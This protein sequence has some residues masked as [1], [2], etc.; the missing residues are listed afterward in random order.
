MRLELE[1]IG[2]LKGKHSFEFKKGLNL[3]VA[4][5]GRGASSVVRGMRALIDPAPVSEVLFQDVVKG[6]VT[7]SLDGSEYR[8]SVRRTASGIV[9]SPSELANRFPSSLPSMVIV[10]ENHPLTFGRLSAESLASYLSMVSH[11]EELT[12][13]IEK[14][15][16]NI[17]AEESLLSRLVDEERNRTNQIVEYDKL[18]DDLHDARVKGRDLAESAKKYPNIKES[19]VLIK[20]M[21]EEIGV[22]R[23]EKDEFEKRIESCNRE[24]ASWE[25][26]LKSAK[27]TEG[28]QKALLEQL[29]VEGK[30][31]ERNLRES[32]S[33]LTIFERMSI[34]ELDKCP[35]C[36]FL[37]IPCEFEK[38]SSEELRRCI[39]VGVATARKNDIKC[40]REH[41]HKFKEI[42]AA[43]ADLKI[44][45]NNSAN[46]TDNI[47]RKQSERKE[48]RV[49]LE[50]RSLELQKLQSKYKES[51]KE[52]IEAAKLLAEFELVKKR[53]DDLIAMQKEK[54]ANGRP[55]RLNTAQK[56]RVEKEL[57]ENRKELSQSKAALDERLHAIRKIF[58][59][60]AAKIMETAGYFTF[61]KLFID[62][63]YRIV[64]ERD[65]QKT[66]QSLSALSTS[67]ITSIAVLIAAWG[68]KAYCPDFPF[69]AIDTVSTFYD[70]RTL[71][72]ISKV[73]LSSG[74]YVVITRPVPGVEN[75]EV[76]HDYDS[77][78]N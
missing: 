32:T 48:A 21:A 24:I 3:V 4:R 76:R 49:Q 66:S 67:E 30:T 41:D 17:A 73:A 23:K 46:A 45:M 9:V 12:K 59:K 19:N 53:I 7:L 20:K 8:A 71:Q 15:S 38:L 47:R 62:E 69:L 78:G 1:N 57:D 37:N 50:K 14:L 42:K 6:S 27:K 29:L 77:I 34:G 16:A 11:S 44:S 54:F 13:K 18:L 33:M 63:N 64:I 10:D 74:G 40:Q 35:I 2:G 26:Q 58:N 36:S 22:I 60:E 31:T 39:E 51:G 25:E 65:R 70:V 52:M 28:A 72:W 5:N 61:E 55:L 68:K 43:K 75:I 56:R